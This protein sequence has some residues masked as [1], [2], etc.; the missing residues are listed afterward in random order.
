MTRD[1]EDEVRKKRL[2][3]GIGTRLAA[4]A[5]YAKPDGILMNQVFKI[6]DCLLIIRKNAR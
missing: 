5:D 4:L 2:I 3:N 1:E 6:R